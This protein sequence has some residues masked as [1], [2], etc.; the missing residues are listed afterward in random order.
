MLFILSIFF[1][2]LKLTL[3][4]FQ[5]LVAYKGPFIKVVLILILL[6]IIYLLITFGLSKYL[7]LSEL[8]NS[9]LRYFSRYQIADR[10]D[11]LWNIGYILFYISIFIGGILWLR[12]SNK[13]ISL[14]IKDQFLKLVTSIAS[15]TGYDNLLDLVIIILFIIIYLY[16]FYRCTKQFGYEIIRLHL[17][18]NFFP[19]YHQILFSPGKFDLRKYSFLYVFTFLFSH[20]FIMD[21]LYNRFYVQYKFFLPKLHN[22]LKN[23]HYFIL[24]FIL[25]F[26]LIFNN[27][28]ILYY[29]KFLPYFLFIIFG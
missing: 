27:F 24:F 2:S 4:V 7:K 10:G 16:F 9:R 11:Q 1:L 3:Q 25:L 12:F 21:Y 5:F 19:R 26:D 14:N 23:L 6:E 20:N 22:F 8:R 18:F 29:F 15:N 13:N 17:Y 28:I